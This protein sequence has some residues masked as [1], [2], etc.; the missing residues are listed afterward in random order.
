[1]LLSLQIAANI[2]IVLRPF[3]PKGCERLGN[4]LNLN[5]DNWDQA[6]KLDLLK[7]GD[8]IGEVSLLF[9]KV[10]D[11]VIEEQI[12]KLNSKIA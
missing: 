8:S 6:G 12:E 9:V 11:E 10:E 4:M 1:M 5:I 3:L 2:T 7:P